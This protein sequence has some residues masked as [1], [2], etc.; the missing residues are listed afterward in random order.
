MTRQWLILADDLTGAADCGIAFAKVG[1]ETVVAWDR[2]TAAGDIPVLSI[3]T[4][5]RRHSPA[6]AAKKQLE[7]LVV[8]HRPGV[9]V[10]KKIDSTL[11]GQPA[12]ELAAELPVLGNLRGGVVPL[13]VIAP[14]FPGTGRTTEQGRILVNGTPLEDT[15]LWA[16]DHTYD[17]ADLPGVL[18]GVGLSS[19][20]M[21]LGLIRQGGAAVRAA[22]ADARLRKVAAVVCDAVDEA[23]LAAIAA[24]SL[25]M[26]DE[27]IWVGSGGLAVHLARQIARGTAPAPAANRD[28]RPVLV[29]VGSLAESS[30]R[31]ADH[32]VETRLVRPVLIS[33]DDL[34]GGPRSDRW[35]EAEADLASHLAGGLDV[36]V[37]IAAAARPDLS[38]GPELA[39]LFARLIAPAMASVGALVV[40]GGDTGCALLSQ[41][42]V[43]GLRPIDE[44]E[45]GVPFGITIGS[46]AIPVVSKAGAFGDEK[47][48]ARCLARLKAE[49]AILTSEAR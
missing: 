28:G 31:Q 21:P 42:G 5:S 37:E 38:R 26:A 35:R 15:P 24:A 47:T 41:L 13:A 30:R 46:L 2:T 43:T 40:T 6:E 29:A 48:L 49:T 45:A 14:A 1:V 25:P 16:R 34:F 17:S 39:A 32:L 12:A 11:R 10:Y 9:L 4:D 44:V 8:H 27:V 19:E 20:V 3:D 22:L 18:A 23:D 33:A 36:L 7:A